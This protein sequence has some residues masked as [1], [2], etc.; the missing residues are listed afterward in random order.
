[1]VQEKLEPRAIWTKSCPFYSTVEKV[2]SCKNPTQDRLDDNVLNPKALMRVFSMSPELTM[3]WAAIS[4]WG[5][6]GGE[7]DGRHTPRGQSMEERGRWWET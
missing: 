7:R 4:V 1:M 5:Q 6:Y 3:G 2:E